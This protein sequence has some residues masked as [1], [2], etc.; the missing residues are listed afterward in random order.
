MREIGWG[1]FL[2]LFLA[3]CASRAPAPV[4]T[5][6]APTPI[7]AA[8]PTASTESAPSHVV[9][10]GETLFGVA[11]QYGIPPRELAAWNGL[12]LSARLQVGQT[13]RLAPAERSAAPAASPSSALAA[14]VLLPSPP[15][16]RP[17]AGGESANAPAADGEKIKN[18][19]KGGKL[20]YSEANL[21]LL[22]QQESASGRA[23][24]AMP[25]QT[26]ANEE[27][28]KAPERPAE[29]PAEKPPVSAASPALGEWVWPATGKLLA[30]FDDSSNSGAL[31]KGIDIAGKIGDPVLAAN[32]GKVILVS[33]ALRGYGNLVIISHGSELLSVY[34]HNSKVLVKEGQQ[35]ARGQK[36]AEIGD[37]DASEAKLHFE[38]RHKGKPVDPMKFLPGR[39]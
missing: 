7:E 28:A 34:A 3:A 10:K 29:K 20:P 11:R 23:N 15:S 38:I 18:A 4:G 37:T 33:N 22:R 2:S 13:L 24:E 21:A 9:K 14:P 39:P 26:R 30:T 12:D 32:A 17:L 31:R 19:P 6:G 1:L 35:V 27:A 36:I 16:G 25:A 8:L 5:A